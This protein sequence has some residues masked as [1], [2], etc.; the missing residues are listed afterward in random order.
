MARILFLTSRF[1]FPLNKG[2]RLRVYFQLRDLS[3]EHEIHLVAIDDHAISP[4]HYKQV[5]PFCKSTSVYIL[6]FYKRVLQLALSLF[7]RTPL[8]VAFFYS[9]NI[10]RKIK[11]LVAEIQPDFIHCHLI[12]TTEYVKN[13]PGIQKSLDFMD[14]FGKGMEKRES[15][16]RNFFKRFLFGYE[17]KRLYAYEREVF[18][19]INRFCIISKQDKAAIPHSRKNEIQIVPNGVDFVTF[20]PREEPQR[21]DLL[22]MGNLGYPPNIEAVL[23]LANEILPLVQQHKPDIRLLIAGVEAPA[24]IKALQ[25]DNIDVIENF[26][27]ISDSIAMSAIMLA[28]M[29]ISIGLQNK[30]LQ[31][32]AMKVP[33][34]V[35]AL[36]NNAV[37]APNQVAIVEADTPAEYAT[38]IMKLLN[39]PGKAKSIGH[40]GYDFV[41]QHY[42]WEQQNAILAGVITNKP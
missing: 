28:P 8:Q 35:S 13:I 41:K 25:S 1:P 3:R 32:M 4:E 21:Y 12:R 16:E 20:F 15:I 10:E 2:D 39:D 5:A 19:F 34:I 31:A 33:C 42:S 38:E 23:F 22:F 40:A 7:R 11:S 18:D 24:R 26:D 37:S 36:S 14:A 9:K 6:P 27:D 29:K 17:K 30:I